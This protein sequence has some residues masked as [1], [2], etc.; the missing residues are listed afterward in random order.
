MADAELQLKDWAGRK[1]GGGYPYATKRKGQRGKEK[2]Y[3]RKR[4]G[5]YYMGERNAHVYNL[6]KMKW[7]KDRKLQSALERVNPP[8]RLGGKQGQAEEKEE[9]ESC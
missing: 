3:N 1:T 8:G 6:G 2:T 7:Q 5:R 4:R 9:G